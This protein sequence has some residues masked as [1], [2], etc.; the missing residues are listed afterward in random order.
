MTSLTS[1]LVGRLTALQKFHYTEC[2][3]PYSQMDLNFGGDC[4]SLSAQHPE[5][6][7]CVNR[8]CYNTLHY[9]QFFSYHYNNNQRVKVDH[10]HEHTISLAVNKQL[11]KH[12]N[13]AN[14]EILKIQKQVFRVKKLVGCRPNSNYLLSSFA[15]QNTTT[16]PPMQPHTERAHSFTQ[17]WAHEHRQTEVISRAFSSIVNAE[18]GQQYKCFACN[19]LLVLDNLVSPWP[20]ISYTDLVRLA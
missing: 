14:T 18:N 1:F 7:Q 19:T 2:N 11:P 4:P 20:C 6:P 8:W 3:H 9:N 17:A 12:T 10:I 16:C 15:S 5:E 13:N